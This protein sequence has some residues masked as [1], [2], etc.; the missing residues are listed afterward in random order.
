[1]TRKE[2]GFIYPSL[3]FY[4]ILIIDIKKKDIIGVIRE[5]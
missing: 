5:R 2:K 3:F 1:M 4:C